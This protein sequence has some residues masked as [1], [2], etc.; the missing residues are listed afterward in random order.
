MVAWHAISTMV[1]CGQP[2]ATLRK[3][4]AGETCLGRIGT[5]GTAIV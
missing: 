2:D 4:D 5:A 1:D 3:A